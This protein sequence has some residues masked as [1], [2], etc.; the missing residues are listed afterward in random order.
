[1]ENT[2]SF[3]K[4]IR[5]EEADWLQENDIWAFVLLTYI[6][7]K[8][9]WSE[10][11]PSG[12]RPGEVELGDFKACG[13]PTRQTYREALKRLSHRGKVEII[14][15]N[16]KSQNATTSTTTSKTIVRLIDS[17]IYDLNL[18]FNNH[19]NNHLTTTSQ[20]PPRFTHIYI[21]EGKERK[22][23]SST[24]N[25]PSSDLLPTPI[26]FSLK[27]KS[28]EGIS[29][30]QLDQWQRDYL[31]ISVRKTIDSIEEWYRN[32]PQAVGKIK[33]WEKAVIKW[34]SEDNEK[35]IKAKETKFK[36][37]A[38]NGESKDVLKVARKYNDR[39]KTCGIGNFSS[40]TSKNDRLIDLEHLIVIDKN[41]NQDE[42]SLTMATVKD[43]YQYEKDLDVFLEKLE[44]H[45]LTQRRLNEHKAGYN[46]TE[47][48]SNINT[49]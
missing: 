24:K 20:P 7:R 3:Y 28:F 35:A 47:S 36:E 9:I 46:L 16:R 21:K 38:K 26:Y 19:L 2:M 17:D 32:N 27:T 41:G 13:I 43:F 29:S 8:A 25:P 1:M 45:L 22:E 6:A 33:N 5:S 49:A 11:H 37:P 23:G 14:T 39:L 12:L 18:N 31:E 44:E 30:E 40:V 34:L 42:I 4:G 15:S 10:N 48:E